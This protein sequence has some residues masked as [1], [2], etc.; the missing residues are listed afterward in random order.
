MAR[1]TSVVARVEAYAT[2]RRDLAILSRMDERL[3]RD[4][5]LN[6]YDVKAVRSG[7]ASSTESGHTP[8][9]SGASFRPPPNAVSSN[10]RAPGGTCI[11]IAW[12]P[13]WKSA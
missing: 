11:A 8:N 6:R 13:R 12:R 1:L 2:Y 3:L 9:D 5:G 7:A 4:A 10:M